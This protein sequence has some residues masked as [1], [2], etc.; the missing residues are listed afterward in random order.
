MQGAQNRAQ[1]GEKNGR[2]GSS[3]SPWG[4]FDAIAMLVLRR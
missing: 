3:F 4:K 2:S 1:K